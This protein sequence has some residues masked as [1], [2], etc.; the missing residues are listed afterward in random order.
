MLDFKNILI[1]Y[2]PPDFNMVVCNKLIM[3]LFRFEKD[4]VNHARIEEKILVPNLAMM[5][6]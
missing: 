5:K 2:T 4:L 6:H 3:E 1:K